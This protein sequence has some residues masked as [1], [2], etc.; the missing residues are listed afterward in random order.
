MYKLE[1]IYIDTENKIINKVQ[2]NTTTTT[3]TTNNNGNKKVIK[4]K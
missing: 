2:C 1:V 3:C 4:K